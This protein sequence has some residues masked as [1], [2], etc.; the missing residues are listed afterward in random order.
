M[1]GNPIQ[2]PTVTSPPASQNAQVLAALREARARIETLERGRREPIAV[3]GTACRLPGGANSAEAFFKLLMMRQDAI[4]PVPANRWAHADY[5]NVDPE[6]PG[7]LNVSGGGFIDLPQ[8]FD[9]EFFGIAPR[10]APSLDPQQRLLLEVS[11]EALEN[12][13]AA[14]DRLKGSEI[15]VFTG[16]CWNDYGQRLLGRPVREIDAY[17]ASGIANSMAAGRLSYILGLHGP[18]MTVDTACSSSLVAVH[19]ACQS[20][21]NGE[22][23]AAIVGAASQLLDPELY[24]NFSKARMLSPDNRCK[25]FDAAADG[26]VRSEGCIVI[27]L[28]RLS[29]ALA[30]QDEVLALIQGSAI[31]HDGHTSG[32]TVPNGPA[33]QDVIRKALRAADLAPADIDYI[34]THGTGTALGDP[35]EVGALGGVFGSANRAAPLVLGAVKSNIGHLEAVSGLA[36]LL[37]VVLA[38]RHET[39]PANLHFK[40]PNPNIEWSR[41]PFTVPVRER[42]WPRSDRTRAAGISSFGFSGTNAHLVVAE[43][44]PRPTPAR[45]ATRPR[46]LLTLSA[47]TESALKKLASRYAERLSE[48]NTELADVAFSANTGRA[49][50]LHRL[51]VSACSS[52]EAASALTSI[53]RL[54]ESSTV[55]RGRVERGRR[56]RVAFLFTGQGSQYVGMGRAL[57]ESNPTF[58]ASLDRC[59]RILSERHGVALLETLYRGGLNLNATQVTQPA[60]FALEY[61]LAEL[62]I[63]WGVTPTHLMGHSVGEYVAACIAGVFSLEDGLAL[64]AAR[65]RLMGA[66]PEGGAMAA[67]LTSESDVA[68]AVAPHA[69]EVGIAGINGPANIVISGNR[70]SVERL[71]QQ[72]TARGIR[73]VPLDVSHAFHSPLVQP[74]VE[75]FRR[76]A[77][78]IAYS[79]PRIDVVSNVSGAVA[80]AEIATADYWCRHVLAPVRFAAGMQALQARG[81]DTFIEMGPRPVL[82]GMGRQCLQEGSTWLPSLRPETGDWEVLLSSIATLFVKDV[83]LDWVAF[84]RDYG[85]KRVALPNYP[86]ERRR[87][88]VDALPQSHSNAAQISPATPVHGLLGSRIPLAT[89]DVVYTNS[90]SAVSPAYLGDHV[91]AGRTLLPATAI[92]E[93]ALKAA[94]LAEA[95]PRSGIAVEDIVIAAPLVLSKSAAVET[96]VV[97][98]SGT[99]RSIRIL[100]RAEGEE[101]WTLHASGHLAAATDRDATDRLDIRAT[102]AA[103]P[104]VVEGAEHYGRLRAAGFEFGPAFQGLRRV[105]RDDRVALGE[106]TMPSSLLERHDAGLQFHPALLDACLQVVAN[107][108][109]AELQP[110]VPLGIARIVVYR[111]PGTTLFSRASL[112]GEVSNS[113]AVTADLTIYDENGARI[114]QIDGFACR[115]LSTAKRVRDVGLYDLTWRLA[116][117]TMVPQAPVPAGHWLIL[118]DESGY[119]EA[120][121]NALR[122]SG[123]STLVATGG[124]VFRR[125]NQT[126]CELDLTDRSQ[127]EQVLLLAPGARWAGAIHC[128]SIG[129]DASGC[130]SLLALVQAI[131][132]TPAGVGARLA[133]VTRGVHSVSAEPLTAS[134]IS[135]GT[136]WGLARVIASEHPQTRCI[137]IDLDLNGSPRSQASPLAAEVLG[138]DSGEEVALRAGGLRYVARLGTCSVASV[139]TNEVAAGAVRLEP[140]RAGTLDELSWRPQARRA[141]D[142]HEVEIEVRATGLGFRDV[143]NSLGMYPGGPVPLGCECSGVVSGVGSAVDHVKVGDPVLAVAY[144]SFATYVTVPSDWVVRKPDMLSYAQ[145][146]AIPSSFLT[147]EYSLLTVARLGRGQRVLIH[148]AAGG[149]GNAA[150][151]VAMKAGAE[152]FATAGSQAKRDYLASI[153]VQH[154]YDS[155]STQFADELLRDTG[156]RGVDVVLNSL[157]DEFIERSFAA[158]AEEGC[159]VELGKR[160][161]LTASQAAQLK[162]RARYV[163]VDLGEIS[164]RQPELVHQLLLQVIQRLESGVY[165]ALPVTSFPMNR[166]TAAFQHM[167]RARHTGKIV[168]TRTKGNGRIG[169]SDLVNA[170]GSCASQA[171]RAD[172]T[173]VVT[174]GMGALGL[175]VARSMVARGAR[176]LALIG[177]RAPDAGATDAIAGLRMEGVEVRALSVDVADASALAAALVQVRATMPPIRGVVHAAGAVDDGV[178]AQ[179]TWDRCRQVLSP[180]VSGGWNLHQLTVADSLDFFVLF[181]AA[182]GILGNPGQGPYAAA[183]VFLDCLA[184]F[185]RSEELPATSIDWGAW[186][187]LGMARVPAAVRSLS[188]HGLGFMSVIQ[189][190]EA[191][192]QAVADETPQRVVLSIDW[193]RFRERTSGLSMP[194]LSECFVAPAPR[195]TVGSAGASNGSPVATGATGASPDVSSVFD[196]ATLLSR[197]PASARYRM[198]TDRVAAEVRAAVGLAAD[199]VI[200]E[201]QPLQELGLDSLMAVELRNALVAMAGLTL[202]ATIVFDYPT[203]E[204][205]SRH[206]LSLLV[207]ERVV[208]S[209]PERAAKVSDAEIAALTDDEAT[210]LL[211]Q[212]LDGAVRS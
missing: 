108:V 151:Q 87:Y 113:G 90:L 171:L 154:T 63:S 138:G 82:L 136:S 121:A 24:V 98:G 35:I 12:A 122:A 164:P 186:E 69:G 189:G 18:S 119:A 124:K 147:A 23:E 123:A 134:S 73:T 4:V 150:I 39:I 130:A 30:N 162:P 192:W 165:S 190:I 106:V 1:T 61:S 193:N 188:A 51:T 34:E 107:F 148:A 64:I 28:K 66:L 195:N 210:E 38:L 128:G 181:S 58:K 46:H 27:V 26:F 19:L 21:R 50:F 111:A 208:S 93:M 43:G 115:S 16:L 144:G 212:E 76:V 5:F 199:Q 182:A 173:Y 110:V 6:V 177:R 57:Y 191:L 83:S 161:I 71:L 65:G 91:V 13:G 158:L 120:L 60:L 85:R 127:L 101:G 95:T 67:V 163:I 75:E 125:L 140:S 45:A 89:S 3:I 20:L 15:G 31:N 129:A 53:A 102:C 48:P 86:F 156:G 11:W 194:L 94:Q 135:G 22:C 105:W 141:P 32:L 137:R 178:L 8:D 176:H 205:I 126:H 170:Q 180:K 10:E 143:L 116:P 200:D 168:I 54:E 197:A 133:V 152:V 112:C 7:T 77:E 72:F 2:K 196:L 159:F 153:G 184:A 79:T 70:S 149:V 203:T 74:V 81:C 40:N 207:P 78:T 55:T 185:R 206:L 36:G 52:A 183:N 118:S 42:P 139:A 14:P 29:D 44:P 62:W 155:R 96:Q 209:Q 100:S 179:Q 99:P 167:A 41:L 142:S 47:R 68:A 80:G 109:P 104:R 59:D 174:G 198:L 175:E 204:A 9:A 92:V 160:G 145:A 97:I 84:D 37:K 49:Q 17:M 33:Q 117:R 187:D 56:P 25:T 114:A 211:L 131:I 172:A 202:P 88:W 146:A 132:A 169:R 103:L 201:R 166:A 157:A